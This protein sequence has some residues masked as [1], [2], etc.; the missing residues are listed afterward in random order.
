MANWKIEIGAETRVGGRRATFVNVI[1]FDQ[2]MIC[3]PDGSYRVVSAADL[4]P[5]DDPQSVPRAFD[6]Y[7]PAELEEA[8]RWYDALKDLLDGKIPRGERS[9]FVVAASLALKAGQSTVWRRKARRH[10]CAGAKITSIKASYCA[11]RR[12]RP[13][14]TTTIGAEKALSSGYSAIIVSR[15]GDIH[16]QIGAL[17][18]SMADAFS[19]SHRTRRKVRNARAAP[20]S[21]RTSKEERSRAGRCLLERSVIHGVAL[22]A[23]QP[24]IDE[25]IGNPCCRGYVKGFGSLSRALQTSKQ[26]WQTKSRTVRH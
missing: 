9:A 15:R 13:C 14:P 24:G 18:T 7:S 10:H 6:D 11:L 22:Q 25:K 12:A 8:Y 26:H 21:T 23:I 19:I 20:N 4:D 1:D 5:K 16:K 3:F 17:T 2:Y